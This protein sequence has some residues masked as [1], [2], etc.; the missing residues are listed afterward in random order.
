[1]LRSYACQVR[2]TWPLTGRTQ[3]TRL[4]EAAL[5]DPGSAGI[6]VSGAAGVGKSR[7]VRETLNAF[8]ARGWLM[9][10]V[11]GT[12]AARNLPF[13]A[14]TP[15]TATSGDDSLELVHG[16]IEAL[17]SS[18]APV[19]VAVDDVPLLDDLSAVVVHQIIHRR[20]AKIVLTMRTGEPVSD[21]TRELWKGGDFDWLDIAPLRPEDTERLVR[22]AVGGPVDGV[23]AQRLWTLTEGNPLY[24]RLIVE[25]EVADGRLAYD[26]GVW[27]WTGDPVV[28]PGLVEL[29]EARTGGLPEAVSDV[30][31]VLAV[32]E[33]LELR[34]LTRIAGAEAVEEADRRGLI[35]CES[36]DG[37]MHVRL[38]HP[39]YGE[40]RRRRAAQTTLR[41]L[42]GVVASEL[43][44]TESR[45]DVH[46]VGRRAALSVDSDLEHDVNLLLDAARG[47]AW[48]LDL[49]LANRLAEAAIAAGGRVEASLIRA[50][51]LSWA[52]KGAAAEAVL[53]DVDTGALTAVE[54]ARVTFLR[55]VNLFFTLADPD[56]ATALVDRTTGAEPP[57]RHCFDAFRCVAAAAL[58]DPHAARALARSF[59][60][61]L[62]P[63]HLERRL[64]AWAVTVACGEAGAAAEA[65]AVANAA[66]PIPVRAFIVISDAHI[67]ALLLAGDTAGAQEVAQMMRGR[68]M[69]SRSTPFGQIADAVTGLAELGGGHLD[70][71]CTNLS[72]ALHRV[73]A[74]NTATGFRYRYEI[75]LTTALAM[76]GHTHDA[77]VAQAAMEADRH[78]GWRYLDYTRA[79]AAG[80][81][82]GAQGAVSEAIS[83]VRKAAED[84]GAR[85]QYAAEVMCLQTA[86]QFGDASTADRLHELQTRVEGPRVGIAARFA[87]A[88][89]CSD[90][91][92]LELISR[93][94]EE[95][96]DLIAATDAAAHA[97]IC[98]RA[99]SLRG[100]SLRCSLRADALAK[101]CG[102]ARTPA[103]RRCTDHLPL[104]TREREIVMLLGTSAS[105]RDIASRLKVSVRTVESHI[106][107]AM[108]KTGAMSREELGALLPCGN[109]QLS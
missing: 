35:S 3:E 61:S 30:I 43:A 80:W 52:G 26:N 67:N 60:A 79:I 5:L 105:N 101:A 22:L 70:Q 57:E 37:C 51:V 44:A 50:F 39:L 100:S 66:Y 31:D 46:A 15:W 109:G 62:L 49:P 13:G 17:T 69:A 40:V 53:A 86:T 64:T 72:T 107:N 28:P 76:R 95:I 25:Q 87:D 71:A 20:L 32:G 10:W 12:S 96:G 93:Q 92:E 18:E 82:A 75:L 23:A 83:M 16:V 34:S 90:G 84:A 97:A 21:A 68:A 6:V 1:M 104:T 78:P 4:I 48:M 42:R 56:A 54:Q 99:R 9:R 63:D 58:G 65:V 74:W 24:L 36:A 27:T 7:I 94:F 33:P 14:L 38:A 106:Y 8:A 59:D 81:V 88:L 11:V 2:L 29:V 19:L 47:A 98:F 73:T 41:R 77:L 102:G 91:R 89:G 108:A 55:A 45:D 85:G 103:L